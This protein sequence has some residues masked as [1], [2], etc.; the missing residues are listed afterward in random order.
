M[1]AFT[2]YGY[3][4]DGSPDRADALIWGLTEL[5][6]RVVASDV[7]S[8]KSCSSPT[9]LFCASGRDLRHRQN[10]PACDRPCATATAARRPGA[11]R[12]VLACASP[13]WAR[14]WSPGDNLASAFCRKARRQL[15]PMKA[16]GGMF[17]GGEYLAEIYGASRRQGT[18]G[19]LHRPDAHPW[20]A[21]DVTFVL[22]EVERPRLP[23]A[24]SST[25]PTA[26]SSILPGTLP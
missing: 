16:L 18:F 24:F 15:R 25:W 14:S 20:T 8:S 11:R 5:F 6:P 19:L 2:T 26:A 12:G 1:I 21:L 13:G 9:V 7:P 3:M 17:R 23:T 10:H 22:L 4:G